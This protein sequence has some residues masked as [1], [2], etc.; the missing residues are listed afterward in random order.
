[1][2]KK[3]LEV[4]KLAGALRSRMTFSQYVWMADE[5]GKP[6]GAEEKSF[7]FAAAVIAM[8]VQAGGRVTLTIEVSTDQAKKIL[9]AKFKANS[10]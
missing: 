7:E 9:P 8:D 6:V 5:R 4:Q 3:A 10:R 1:M 2:K